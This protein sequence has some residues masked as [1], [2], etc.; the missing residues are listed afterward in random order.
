MI[1]LVLVAHGSLARS[2][3]EA[4]AHVTHG[5]PPQLQAIEVEA[6][7][8]CDLLETRLRTAIAAVDDGA[9]VVV[10]SDIYG[11]TPCNMAA[12]VLQPGHVEGVAGMNLPMVLKA[13]GARHQ[14][15]ETMLQAVIE[16]GTVSVVNMTSDCCNDFSRKV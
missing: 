16:R 15:L 5:T 2:M 4:A 13:I 9:G 3:A 12:K 8:D 14:P 1:G 10:L 7:M 6:D 11:A